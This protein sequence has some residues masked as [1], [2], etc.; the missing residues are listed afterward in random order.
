M[1]VFRFF[2]MAAVR[3]VGFVIRLYRPSRIVFGGLCHYAKF[4]WNRCSSFDNM[5][6]VIFREL[7]LKMLIHAPFGVFWGYKNGEIGNVL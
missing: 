2:K 4:G 5:Q 6:I 7:G 3:Q 1:A